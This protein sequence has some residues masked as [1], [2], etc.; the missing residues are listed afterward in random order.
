MEILCSKIHS[1]W[2]LIGWHHFPAML[3]IPNSL[4]CV[5]M[6]CVCM[7]CVF[8]L[9]KQTMRLLL[10]CPSSDVHINIYTCI[11]YF[12]SSCSSSV[13]AT[14]VVLMDISEVHRKVNLELE[15]N[16]STWVFCAGT[17]SNRGAQPQTHIPR[18]SLKP[19]LRAFRQPQA[20]P[21]FTK[22]HL[23]SRSFLRRPPPPP[24]ISLLLPTTFTVT[25]VTQRGRVRKT[26]GWGCWST[27]CRWEQGAGLNML[28]E[29]PGWS[30]CNPWR[31]H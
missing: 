9:R 24:V 2:L 22:H 17:H 20:R 26:T 19:S 8:L 16:V 21:Q 31:L 25:G 23:S 3:R 18:R 29:S 30:R 6:C 13:C 28:P 11:L 4:Y 27:C 14:G 12:P 1:W 15:E 7:Y 5:C 10:A